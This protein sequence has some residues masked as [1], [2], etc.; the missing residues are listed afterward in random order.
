MVIAEPIYNSTIVHA[1]F[2][3]R[4]FSTPRNF[5]WFGF[6]QRRRSQICY[7]QTY[8][9]RFSSFTIIIWQDVLLNTYWLFEARYIGTH[10]CCK[11][12]S[13]LSVENV[14]IMQLCN[15]HIH[16]Q[17]YSSWFTCKAKQACASSSTL[18]FFER[19]QVL[20]LCWVYIPAVQPLS[21]LRVWSWLYYMTFDV[22]TLGHSN[23]MQ[24]PYANWC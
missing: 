14:A 16:M 9:D 7:M 5:L 6:F 13:V 11:Y 22:S 24:M 4:L 19:T 2:H 15:M 20:P 3:F 12:W 8:S 17:C 18:L 10:N 21:A 23:S 1:S